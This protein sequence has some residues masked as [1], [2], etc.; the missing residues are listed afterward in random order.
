MSAVGLLHN[1]IIQNGF[2]KLLWINTANNSTFLDF[3]I[4]AGYDTYWFDFD[5]LRCTVWP[6]Q[7]RIY[8]SANSGSSFGTVHWNTAIRML[9]NYSQS[10]QLLGNEDQPTLLVQCIV[11]VNQCLSGRIRM[12]TAPN[13]FFWQMQSW[14]DTYYMVSS[15]GGGNANVGTVN[16]VRFG[17]SVSG[18]FTD[19]SIRLYG[20]KTGT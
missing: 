2:A 20:L 1:E 19:G 15:Y 5:K 10:G 13:T 16:Y 7:L 6:E 18:Q 11:G 12:R 4:P 9:S 14:A 8:V 17:S 3:S